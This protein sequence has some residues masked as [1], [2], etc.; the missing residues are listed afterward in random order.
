MGVEETA[1]WAGGMGTSV[2]VG[3]C[4][5]VSVVA[6][7]TKVLVEPATVSVTGTFVVTVLV[8]QSPPEHDTLVET[9]GQ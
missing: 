1:G 8:T 9:T 7:E 5:S 6:P 2:P 3:F 4:P